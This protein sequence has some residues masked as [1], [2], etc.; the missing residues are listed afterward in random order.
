MSDVSGA[1]ADRAA[2]TS[3]VPPRSGSTSAP[4]PRARLAE[5]HLASKLRSNRSSCPRKGSLNHGP[6]QP[7]GGDAEPHTDIPV[8][9]YGGSTLPA[10]TA[11][12]VDTSNVISPTSS[13]TFPGVA[14][15]GSAGVP[16]A[17]V[18]VA[19]IA[20]GASGLLRTGGVALIRMRGQ[21]HRRHA[22]P[23]VHHVRQSRLGQTLTSAKAQIGM[24]PSSTDG[25][26][27]SSSSSP[28]TT[29]DRRPH[30]PTPRGLQG[31]GHRPVHKL[32]STA[33]TSTT[34]AAPCV[35]G[36]SLTD[37]KNSGLFSDYCADYVA[38]NLAA[39]CSNGN[40]DAERALLAAGRER[41]VKMDLGTGDV[42]QAA[43]LPNYAA[44]YRNAPPSPTCCPPR[45]W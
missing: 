19:D 27:I 36:W 15:P 43:A 10:N 13:N 16:V 22:R 24:A 3:T 5:G 37:N 31:R 39:G 40:R 41:I 4:P 2:T 12:I 35:A 34:S 38:Q 8:K 9:N 18:L 11:V 1:G 17:G 42:H 29:P 32:D 33:V 28:R 44:G 7:D 14:V 25:E 45:C 6:V 20:A 30:V 21:H 23:G 26:L